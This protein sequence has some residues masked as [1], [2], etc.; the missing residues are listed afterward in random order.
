MNQC[1]PAAGRDSKD[2]TMAAVINRGRG[3]PSKGLRKYIGFRVQV[4]TAEEV[5]QVAAAKGITMSDYI[6]SAVARSLIEDRALRKNF[7]HQEELPI[8]MAS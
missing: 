1:G 3:R 2:E 6:S 5:A 4:E 7:H 8:R